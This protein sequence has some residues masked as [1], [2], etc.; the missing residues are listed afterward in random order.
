MVADTVHLTKT[1]IV[2]QQRCGWYRDGNLSIASQ[3]IA[4]AVEYEWSFITLNSFKRHC[5]VLSN[6]NTWTFQSNKQIK[7]DCPKIFGKW[8]FIKMVAD[9]GR[10]FQPLSSTVKKKCQFVSSLQAIW[11][12]NVYATYSF[13]KYGNHVFSFTR[14]F[15]QWFICTYTHFAHDTSYIKPGNCD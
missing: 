12:S 8:I 2:F 15:F 5:S 9:N 6:V 7:G 11:E 14:A 10:L 4:G 3:H 1:I 13:I